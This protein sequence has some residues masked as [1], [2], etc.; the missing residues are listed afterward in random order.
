MVALL[1][2]AASQ[3]QTA[4]YQPLVR[5]GVRWIYATQTV[6]SEDYE[7]AMSY[8][9]LEFYGDTTI[10]TK[11]GSEVFKKCYMMGAPAQ[12][13]YY[14]VDF[15]KRPPRAFLREVD[16]KVY[17]I[18]ASD[19]QAAEWS[20]EPPRVDLIYDFSDDGKVTLVG[21]QGTASR[22]FTRQSQTDVAG[23]LCGVFSEGNANTDR[24]VESIGLVSRWDGDL[25]QA[26][27]YW[28]AGP[29]T[30]YGLSHVVTA[31]GEV[32]FKGPNYGLFSGVNEVQAAAG[33]DSRWY[34][35]TGVAFAG[36]PSQPGLYIHGGR[37]V[38][39]R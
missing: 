22:T 2:S 5:E 23:H 7:S 8:Y 27:W 15:S 16:R 39:I 33:D 3:G 32:I 18:E 17:L 36:R 28:E 38:I 9:G 29:T 26:R 6:Y 1:G 4:D 20:G 19:L 35:V 37:K 25:Y 24:I 14:K 11:N 13:S 21:M 34:I 31:D 10:V 30:Y 12:S